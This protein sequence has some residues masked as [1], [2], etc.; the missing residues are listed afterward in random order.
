MGIYLNSTV[1]LWG[2]TVASFLY[3]PKPIK[4]G[5]CYGSGRDSVPAHLPHI[6]LIC[7]ALW[8]CVKI[9]DGPLMETFWDPWA[10]PLPQ[11]SIHC[12]PL[13][14]FLNSERSRWAEK[15][16]PPL[17]L[18]ISFSFMDGLALDTLG[19][20]QKEQRN[21]TAREVQTITAGHKLAKPQCEVQKR[22]PSRLLSVWPFAPAKVQNLLVST[23]LTARWQTSLACLQTA[24]WLFISLWAAWNWLLYPF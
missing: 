21:E 1:K 19:Q 18:A 7:F 3:M 6:K 23:D 2:N 5:F 14:S 10:S 22:L 16:H 4:P 9:Y 24:S 11:F 8:K 12:F 15:V 13:V 17:D 20:S